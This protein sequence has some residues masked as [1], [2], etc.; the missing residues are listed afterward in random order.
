MQEQVQ[1]VGLSCWFAALRGTPKADS[2]TLKQ[3]RLLVLF[4]QRLAK[5]VM[6]LKYQNVNCTL[7]TKIFVSLYNQKGVYWSVNKSG[8]KL[9]LNKKWRYVMLENQV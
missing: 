5:D 8:K 6:W 3:W 9:M 1:I 4:V 7:K 2:Q